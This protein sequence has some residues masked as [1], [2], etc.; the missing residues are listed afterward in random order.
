MCISYFIL[1]DSRGE[2][3]YDFK[4][5]IY[6]SLSAT[7]SQPEIYRWFSDRPETQNTSLYC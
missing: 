1:W 6:G 2:S 3:N 7:I 4:Y 5:Q